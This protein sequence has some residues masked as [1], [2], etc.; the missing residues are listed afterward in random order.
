M[1]EEGGRRREEGGGRKE[2]EVAEME[3]EGFKRRG[4]INDFS[5]KIGNTYPYNELGST[6][7]E[8]EKD[9]DEEFVIIWSLVYWRLDFREANEDRRGKRKTR[10]SRKMLEGIGRKGNMHK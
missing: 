10:K 4:R 2:V 6:N 5:R 8:L 9:K 1:R 7:A 3:N